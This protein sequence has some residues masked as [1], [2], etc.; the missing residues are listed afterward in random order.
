MN[1]EGE[2]DHDAEGQKIKMRTV[3]RP[4]SAKKLE[5]HMVTH[6]PFRNWC[7]HCVA[8][9][10]H[11][12]HHQRQLRDVEQ[13]VPTISI[14]YAFMNAKT[15]VEAKQPI[16]VLK[17]RKSGT[18]KAHVVEEKGVNAYAIK[19]IGQDIGLLGYNRI[20][21]K[22]DNEPAI[23]ALKAAIKAERPEEIIMEESPVGESAVIHNL[24]VKRHRV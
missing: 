18:I 15:A 3:G 16:I 22:S 4:S 13:E 7:A 21:L 23:M 8:G 1:F 17:D 11:S 14:D 19:R 2:L 20:I 6:I 9:R 24:D 10:G 12:G 5:E